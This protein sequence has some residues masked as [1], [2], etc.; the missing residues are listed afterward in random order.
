MKA[1]GY[2]QKSSYD[3]LDEFLRMLEEGV[4]AVEIPFKNAEYMMKIYDSCR[5]IINKDELPIKVSVSKKEMKL[6]VFH[7]TEKDEK[8]AKSE[9]LK[10]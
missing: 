4:E 6:W 8:A 9:G 2:Y 10:F 5:N 3:I 7:W 1:K